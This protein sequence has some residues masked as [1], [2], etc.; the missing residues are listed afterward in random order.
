MLAGGG[1]RRSLPG[2]HRTIGKGLGP[3]LAQAYG[4]A[5]IRPPASLVGM[6]PSRKESNEDWCWLDQAD[7]CFRRSRQVRMTCRFFRH[8]AGPNGIPLLASLCIRG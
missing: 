4:F 7:L 3:L 8:H 5:V 2:V 1:R 6:R